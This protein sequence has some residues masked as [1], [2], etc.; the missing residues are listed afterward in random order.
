ML[1]IV[2]NFYNNQREA[3]RT[4]YALTRSYQRGAQDLAYEVIAIDNGSSESLSEAQVR[5]LGPQFS[6]HSVQTRSVSPVQAI[7]AACREATGEQL[8]VLIDG[9]QIVSPGVLRL[10]KEAFALFPSA[11]VATAWFHLGP[12]LQ[13][14]SVQEG[15]NQQVEDELLSRSD[16][17][18][19]GYRLY[20]LV[21]WCEDAAGGWF[22]CL[23]ESAC[24]AIRK[25][26]YLA[27]GGFDERF[28]SR[29]GGL[30]N[31][32]FFQRALSRQDLEYVMLLGEATFHQVHDGVASSVPIAQH[33]WPAFHEEYV[34]IR[35]REF[36][37][38][39][40]R[41]FLLGTLP[42]E[43]LH[44]AQVSAQIGLEIWKGFEQWQKNQAAG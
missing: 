25:A 1:S 27:M 37:R 29:G 15:Y 33:P 31:L 2:V 23:F 44:A 3:P 26:D 38:V 42:S 5:A 14:L 35:G 7:N 20:N 24:F 6:Y 17:K 8:L 9:A 36:A 39:P 34:R 22:G 41:P 30:A 12:K 32:D 19:N 10:A 18:E 13:N 43:A 16:W 11:F 4:L 21:G 28:Q 40:R